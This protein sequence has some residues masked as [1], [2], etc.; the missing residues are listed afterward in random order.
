MGSSSPVGFPV[1]GGGSPGLVIRGGSLL[2]WWA[3]PRMWWLPVVVG[4]VSW[5]SGGSRG[6]VSGSPVV[7]GPA[8]VRGSRVVVHGSLASFVPLLS[9]ALL[10]VV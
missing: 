2:S 6:V 10:M 1:V 8:T 7:C 5:V 4:G 3:L 9:P